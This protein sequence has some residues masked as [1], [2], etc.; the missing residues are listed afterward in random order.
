MVRED[1]KVH[2]ET[3]FVSSLFKVLCKRDVVVVEEVKFL[4][5]RSKHSKLN[6]ISL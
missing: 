2:L 1:G 3:T 6:C 5:E 4:M